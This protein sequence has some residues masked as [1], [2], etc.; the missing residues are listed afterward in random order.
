M[1]L[2]FP[3][4]RELLAKGFSDRAIRVLEQL[5]DFAETVT[6]V[7]ATEAAQEQTDTAVDALQE[8]Q[9]DANL[10]LSTLD[11]RVDALEAA[12]PYVEAGGDTMTGA[13]DVQALLQCDSFRIDAA[14]AA[15]AAVA[16]TH[17]L[18]ISCN[19]TTYYI[20]LSNV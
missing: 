9:E 17:K 2:S 12:G 15:A 5:S 7:A 10:S 19:G 8:A 20:L 16:S 1:G 13:L 18:A 11:T 6:R 4:R 3:I 14:P